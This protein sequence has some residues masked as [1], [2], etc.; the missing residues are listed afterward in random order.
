MPTHSE[1]ATAV[2][3]ALRRAEALAGGWEAAQEEAG[4]GL[5]DGRK[6]RCWSVKALGLLVSAG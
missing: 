3:S 1:Q 2:R 4:G 6:Q 5:T